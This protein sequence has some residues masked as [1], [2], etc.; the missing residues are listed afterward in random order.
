MRKVWSFVDS[1]GEK[2]SVVYYGG[3]TLVFIG[4]EQYRFSSPD[5]AKERL[6]TWGFREA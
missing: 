6:A 3:I 2:A 1:S 4:E 5:E